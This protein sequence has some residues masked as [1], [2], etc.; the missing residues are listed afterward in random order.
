[1]F[2]NAWINFDLTSCIINHYSAAFHIFQLPWKTYHNLWPDW[3]ICT[4]RPSPKSTVQSPLPLSSWALQCTWS[5]SLFERWSLK[6]PQTAS[7]G[8]ERERR[9]L[10]DPKS[11]ALFASSFFGEL[12][13][14]ERFWIDMDFFVEDKSP[15]KPDKSCRMSGAS[16][17]TIQSIPSKVLG[18][19]LVPVCSFLACF[20]LLVTV[21]PEQS[22]WLLRKGEK[23]FVEE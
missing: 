16:Q 14:T 11:S 3:S 17:S 12:L 20:F 18:R 2:S 22:I 7:D 9:W 5:N 21:H 8:N 10:A 23:S 4:S 13:G 19:R 15:T 1:M 6:S